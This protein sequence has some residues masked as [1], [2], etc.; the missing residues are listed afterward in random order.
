MHE[1]ASHDHLT[2]NAAADMLP[3]PTNGR[4]RL[5]VALLR[6]A[7]ATMVLAFPAMLLPNDWMAATHE[8]LGLGEFPRRP[9]VEYLA[10]S[11]AALYGFHGVLLLMLSSDPLRYRPILWYVAA[12]NVLFGAM[13]VVVDAVAGMPLVWTLGE[14]PPIIAFGLMIGWLIRSLSVDR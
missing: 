7:G 1:R 14:G 5:L 12:M 6:L 10:R 2:S 9:V 13:M 3:R 4:L 11:I 8:W